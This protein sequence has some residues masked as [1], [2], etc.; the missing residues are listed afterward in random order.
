MT[1]DGVLEPTSPATSPCQL[2]IDEVA[3]RVSTFRMEQGALCAT[4]LGT[5]PSMRTTQA[6]SPFTISSRLGT[7]RLPRLSSATHSSS[8]SRPGRRLS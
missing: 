2:Q 7:N 8:D 1:P 5:L 6:R 3:D 4:E